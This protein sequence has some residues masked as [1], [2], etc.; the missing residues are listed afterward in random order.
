[1]KCINPIIVFRAGEKD[2]RKEG[3]IYK[4]NVTVPCGKCF[5]CKRTKVQQWVFRLLEEDKVSSSS[6]FITLT[7]NT[8]NLPWSKEGLPTL[9]K[10]DLQKYWKRL[11]KLE[12]DVKIKYYAVGEYGSLTFRPHYHAIVYNVS[13]TANIREAWKLAGRPLGNVH[14]GNVKGESVAYVCK[15]I[16]KNAQIPRWKGDDRV[17]EFSTMSNNLGASFLTKSVIKQYRTD[18]TRNFVLDGEK[19]I[20]LPK[21]YSNKIFEGHNNLKAIRTANIQKAEIEDEKKKLRAYENSGKNITYERWLFEEM[22]HD[23]RKFN[24]NS[25]L[26]RNKI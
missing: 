12:K 15:Y 24:K 8:E 7:Y 20:P 3:V 14:I 1:M 5:N 23:E 25:K 9:K 17:K 19:K 2:R 10:D 18:L 21:Y 22:K 13:N 16:D 26:F 11:R 4:Q 6:Y